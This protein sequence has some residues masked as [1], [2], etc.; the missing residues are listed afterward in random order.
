MAWR[1]AANSRRAQA[2]DQLDQPGYV[3]YVLALKKVVNLYEAKT[4]L[5]E[6]VDRA[7]AGEDIVI[8]KAGRPRAKLVRL[9]DRQKPRK[10]G[11]WK[12]KVRI[13]P[14]FDAPLPPE[15]LEKFHGG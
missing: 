10:P 9:P 12:G 5:S 6:L 1:S 2:L 11:G 4:R 15:V 14:D 7:A 3:T 13:A 8:A